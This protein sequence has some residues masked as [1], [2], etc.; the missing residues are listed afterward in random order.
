MVEYP[1]AA[2]D[3][4]LAALADPTRRAIIRRLE[5]GAAKV[6][7]L[8]K[9]FDVSLNAISK[10]LRVL[11]RAG[12]MRRTVQGRDH[13]CALEAAPMRGAAEWIEHYRAFWEGRLDAL[14]QYLLRGARPQPK[15][16]RK[17]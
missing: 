17:R 16:R 2:L 5:Q 11:E 6:T 13:F 15:G 3:R 10:H 9:P 7:D 8:A 12:L 14:E 4:T 1:E